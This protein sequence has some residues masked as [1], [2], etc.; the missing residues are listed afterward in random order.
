M[1]HKCR[2]QSVIPFYG[3]TKIPEE[4]EY[5]MVIRY[6]KYGDLRNYI[7]KSFSNLNWTDKANILI[8]LSNALNSL[9]KMNL[10]HRDFH[11]KNILVD[12]EKRIFINDF[13]LCQSID[14]EIGE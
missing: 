9:H 12:E 2:S 6:A 7:R 1:H 3:I 11:C 14:S 10:L 8:E 5:A 4:D 13:E